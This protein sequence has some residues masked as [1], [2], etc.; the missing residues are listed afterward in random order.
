M[1]IADKPCRDV[2]PFEGRLADTRLCV[3]ACFLAFISILAVLSAYPV[4]AQTRSSSLFLQSTEETKGSYGLVTRNNNQ[5]LTASVPK[6]IRLFN[7]VEKQFESVFYTL[8]EVSSF[9][10]DLTVIPRNPARDVPGG[11]AISSFLDGRVI[12]VLNDGSIYQSNMEAFQVLPETGL[13]KATFGPSLLGVDGI[14]YRCQD[15]RLYVAGFDPYNLYQL[16]WQG[17]FPRPIPLLPFLP[18][19]RWLNSFDFGPDGLLYA[20]DVVH[21]QIVVIDVTTG[22]VTPLVQ[23]IDKPAAVKVDRDGIVYFIGRR[24]GDVYRHNPFTGE[25]LLLATLPPGLDNL[26]LDR[27]GDKLYVTNNQNQLFEIDI[28]TRETEILFD[29]PVA[30]MWDFAYDSDRRSLHV[31]DLASIKEFNADEATLES[32]FVFADLD[33]GLTN[34]NFHATSLTLDTSQEGKIILTDMFLGNILVLNRADYSIHD[35]TLTGDYTG[36]WYKQPS[37]TVRVENNDGEYYLAA[38]LLDGTIVKISHNGGIESRNIVVESFASGLDAPTK[39]KIHQGY[40]YIVELGQTS[41]GLAN[42]GK[43]SRIS[44]ANPRIKEV[45]VSNLAEPQG[46]D[47]VDDV[48]YFIESKT[49]RLLKASALH[50]DTAQMVEENLDLS[51]DLF[52]SQLTP[53]AQ[54]TPPAAVAVPP[55]A[56]KIY[57]IETQPNAIRLFEEKD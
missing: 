33:S 47:I 23:N 7:V 19:G 14:A 11:I 16:D 21:G 45:L 50:P 37:S 25:S 46:L 15:D 18:E 42:N 36:L 26:T 3:R 1:I 30:Q 9:P 5:L 6:V 51:S 44:L 39:L 20:P 57:V 52:V 22:I 34:L 43:I 48:M 56:E 2:Y 28:A 8:T 12:T 29:S 40:V 17:S 4:L 31:T 35:Q 24:T 53:V 54:S 55:Q 32:H 41:K 13:Y 27:S 10:L 38:S 49:K